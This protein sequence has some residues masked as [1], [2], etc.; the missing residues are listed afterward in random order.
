MRDREIRIPIIRLKEYIG[1]F[2]ITVTCLAELSGI[3]RLH[4]SKCMSGEVDERSGRKRTMSDENMGRL[5]ESLHQ[6]SLKLRYTFILYNT[7]K[8]VVKRNGSRYCPDCVAQIKSQLSPYLNI[9][10]FVQH[11][12]GWNRSKVRNVIDNKK[13]IIYGN[14]SKDDVNRINIILREIATRLDMLTVTR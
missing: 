10:P 2:G 14:I 12:L 8:E 9:L 5:Q 3:K 7:D 4:L 6:L 13:S 1:E 11:C